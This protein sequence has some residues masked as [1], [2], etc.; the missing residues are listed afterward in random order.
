M[1]LY[2]TG[3]PFIFMNATNSVNDIRTLMHESGHAIHS[4]LSN[5]YP[6]VAA[7]KLPAE[8][9][10]LAA[11]TMELLTLDAWKHYFSDEAAF[12]RAKLFQL[13][14][15]LRVLPWI[16]A[17]DQF[18][19]WIYTNYGHSQEAR[20]Q[21]WLQILQ[22]FTPASVK[23]EGLE[24]YTEYLWH[25]QLHIFEVPFYYIEYGIAQL[26]AIGI[27]QRYRADASSALE[28]YMDALK[29][30]YTQPVRTVYQTAGVPFDFSRE[31]V[32]QLGDFVQSEIE[33]VME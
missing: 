3:T 24:S 27:W 23:L 9:A 18:Q 32:Q 26:G 17:I 19:H 28:G 25:K 2:M 16:A 5:H 30:G 1:P 4:L 14:N 13:E 12:R 8:I 29:L 22:R 7:K 33:R 6:L 11:M 20:R 10:E 21:K 31:R 15:M